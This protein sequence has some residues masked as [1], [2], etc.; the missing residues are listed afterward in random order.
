MSILLSPL[1]ALEDL[2]LVRCLCYGRLYTCKVSVSWMSS[3][4]VSEQAKVWKGSC[5]SLAPDVF[6]IVGQGEGVPNG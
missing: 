1:C 6:W 4:L 2:E 5:A 3:T